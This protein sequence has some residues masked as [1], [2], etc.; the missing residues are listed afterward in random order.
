MKEHGNHL[1]WWC[2]A[3]IGAVE[4]IQVK[5]N[6]FKLLSVSDAVSSKW[7]VVNTMQLGR[8]LLAYI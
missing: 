1:D 6:I 4:F 3:K 8:S 7:K 2:S 5:N